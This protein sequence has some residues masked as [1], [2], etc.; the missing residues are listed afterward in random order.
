M[1]D[2]GK[3]LP[4]Q[5]VFEVEKSKER[6]YKVGIEY[7]FEYPL[8]KEEKQNL[9]FKENKIPSLEAPL[10]INTQIVKYEVYTRKFKNYWNI[11]K[12]AT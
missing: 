10:D 11:S 1:V 4:S 5:V 3:A 8:T 9:Y 12:I 6:I 2:I 7:H